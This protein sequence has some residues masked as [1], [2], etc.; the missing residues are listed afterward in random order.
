MSILSSGYGAL[1]NA[2]EVGTSI[3]LSLASPKALTV[4]G[5][6]FVAGDVGKVIAVPGIGPSSGKLITTISA[7]ADA[8]H[9]TLAV[10]ASTAKTAFAT[11]VLVGTNDFTN[12]QSAFTAVANGEVLEFV[13][14][15][16][17][18][19]TDNLLM[20]SPTNATINGNNATIYYLEVGGTNALGSSGV[21]TN[22]R[23]SD[24]NFDLCMR[25]G[26]S[27]AH[28]I[29]MGDPARCVID[30]CSAYDGTGGFI[31]YRQTTTAKEL[32]HD[33]HIVRC[34]VD[35]N[36]NGDLGIMLSGCVYSS[37]VDC[38]VRGGDRTSPPV[39]YG[40][41]LKLDCYGCHITGGTVEDWD[42]AFVCASQIGD[43][44]SSNNQVVDCSA[45]GCRSGLFT[46]YAENCSF[47][48]LI[49]QQAQG[50]TAV[51]ITAQSDDCDYNV[52]IQN[53]VAGHPAIQTA[54]D[55]QSFIIRFHDGSGDTIWQLDT[56]AQENSLVIL[57]YDTTTV[58]FNPQ[59]QF[60]DNSGQTSNKFTYLKAIESSPTGPAMLYLPAGSAYTRNTTIAVDSGNTQ[61]SHVVGGTTMMNVSLGNMKVGPGADN[62]IA[63]AS[64]SARWSNVF[65]TNVR[66][67]AGTVIWTSG[68][69]APTVVAPVGSLYTRTDGAAGLTL[70]V[71]E[72]G[73][74]GTGWVAI[75]TAP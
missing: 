26:G 52:A 64:A 18:L 56:G 63:L 51:S 37:I 3:T 58:T 14:N 17:Y 8:T 43:P 19:V 53:M 10:N 31:M 38:Y 15:A 71:K 67:G 49:D 54:S 60:I 72:S 21:A 28:A 75:K 66:P 48:L 33:N 7:V 1:G 4:A 36:G 27:G 20:T 29:S 39:G 47:S 35:D 30:N 32:C 34:N 25:Y 73:T 41:E 23:I 44:I 59:S 45:L 9:V 40:Q 74:M 50:E 5:G 70:Y 13:P 6:N 61:M 46:D 2:R 57:D 24:L 12:L 42:V 16:K 55:R 65:A 11:S 69:G 62:T 22:T 68:A